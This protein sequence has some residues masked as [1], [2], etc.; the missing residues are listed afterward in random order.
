MTNPSKSRNGA[1]I[2]CGWLALVVGLA[3]EI[4]VFG[5]QKSYDSGPLPVFVFFGVVFSGCYLV[6]SII[7]TWVV[8]WIFVSRSVSLSRWV[9]GLAGGVFFTIATIVWCIAF[10]DKK[11]EDWLSIVAHESLVAGFVLLFV[12]DPCLKEWPNKSVQTTLMT[13][14]PSATAPA[15]L[16]DL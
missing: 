7:V 12:L 10:G 16:S 2:F 9:W 8:R 3:L 14:P 4:F 6:T 11:P 1:A 15:P 13:H 5:Q